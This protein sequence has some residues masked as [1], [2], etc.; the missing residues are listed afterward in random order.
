MTGPEILHLQTPDLTE[1]QQAN[2]HSLEESLYR[3]WDL[4]K[5]IVLNWCPRE[6]GVDVTVVPN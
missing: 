6:N 3:H 4:G 1:D 2:L 5:N